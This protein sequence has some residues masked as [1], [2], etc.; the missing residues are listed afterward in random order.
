MSTPQPARHEPPEHRAGV[1]QELLAERD[2]LEARLMELDDVPLLLVYTHLSGDEA[3]LQR[4]APHIKGAWAFEVDPVPE[5]KRE[6]PTMCSS[7]CAA[8]PWG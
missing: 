8:M 6:R 7:A 5:L 2:L 4:Y 1:L 3:L